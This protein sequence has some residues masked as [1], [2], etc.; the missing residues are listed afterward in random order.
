MATDTNMDMVTGTNTDMDKV[1]GTDNVTDTD[2]E[3]VM[4]IA[5]NTEMD[6]DMDMKMGTAQHGPGHW[7]KDNK[8]LWCSYPTGTP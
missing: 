6:T 3:K 2:M 5:R 1:M 4:A 8:P 7:I